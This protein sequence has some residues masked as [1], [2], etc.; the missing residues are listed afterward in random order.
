GRTGFLVDGHNPAD[1]AR[2]LGRFADEPSL[3]ASMGEAAARHAQSF[4]WDTA[5]AATADVYTAATQSHRRRVR[6]HHG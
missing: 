4:G 3:A 5:A 2:V 6:S 1:Y